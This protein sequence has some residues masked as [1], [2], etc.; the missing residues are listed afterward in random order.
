MN[1]IPIS[2]IRFNQLD[3]FKDQGCGICRSSLD[4][5]A[6]ENQEASSV[7]PNKDLIY[8]LPC[9]HSF[10]QNGIRP[11]IVQKQ[12]PICPSCSKAYQIENIKKFKIVPAQKA[13]EKAA[14]PA[15]G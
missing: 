10:H 1:A 8:Q 9:K 7:C 5:C 6:E 14:E 2:S 15:R 4:P 3:G 11:W 12:P 13:P